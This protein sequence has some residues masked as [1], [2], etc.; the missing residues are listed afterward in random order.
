MGRKIDFWFQDKHPFIDCSYGMV[1]LSL[2][3]HSRAFMT[4]IKSTVLSAY[5][6]VAAILLQAT[7]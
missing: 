1:S 6:L 3:V 2:D 7:S 4:N 5:P